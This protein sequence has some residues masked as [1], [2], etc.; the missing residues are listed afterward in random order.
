MVWRQV[1]V[2]NTVYATGRFTKARPPGTDPGSSREVAARNI[3]AY[4][5]RTGRR[6]K[7]FHPQMNGQ[8]FAIARSPDGKRIYVGGD[9]TKVNGHVHR[10]IVAFNTSTKRVASSFKASAD[11]QVRAIAVSPSRVYF[12]GKFQHVNGKPRTRLA[13]VGTRGKLGTRWKPTADD[14]SVRAMV[15]SPDRSRL[16]VGGSFTTLNKTAAYGMGAVSLADGRTM[17]WAANQ[18][19]RNAG[20]GGAIV[21]LRRDG[22]QIYGSGYAF[23]SNGGA[24]F[25]GTFAANPNT[26]KINWVNDC[27]GDTYDVLPVGKLLYSVGHAHDCSPIGE[28]GDTSPVSYHRALVSWKTPHGSNGADARGGAWNNYIG[29]PAARHLNWFPALTQGSATGQNQAAWSLAGNGKYIS[30]GG[31]FPKANGHAQQGLVRYAVPGLAPNKVGSTRDFAPSATASA[32]PN[33]VHFAWTE[34]W[35]QDNQSLTYRVFRKPQGGPAVQVHEESGSS[36]FWQ[37]DA[38]SYDDT[39]PSPGTYRYYV[40]STDPYGNTRQSDSVQVTIAGVGG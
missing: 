13:A 4:D 37:R 27:H 17:P 35:D 11:K 19:I 31:E 16:I 8:G 38:L 1:M 2:G 3:F 12:G 9:F 20:S 40:V 18:T 6:V 15:L 25:E 26:G 39:A 33:T 30:L 7:S 24:N 32:V 22:S 28:F 5:I 36:T 14:Y 21:S 10:H 23:K 34:V 29:Q